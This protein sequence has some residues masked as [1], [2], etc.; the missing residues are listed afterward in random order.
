[1]HGHPELHH[2]SRGAPGTLTRSFINTPPG[3]GVAHK[4]RHAAS[5]E[6]V[7][8]LSECANLTSHT[9]PST[10]SGMRI[11]TP[12]CCR[13]AAPRHRARTSGQPNDALRCH[14][15]ILASDLTHKHVP[16]GTLPDRH[17]N[18][19]AGRPLAINGKSR[20]CYIFATVHLLR[21]AGR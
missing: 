19:M 18:G 11:I 20:A 9:V 5:H 8:F 4:M 2:W 14:T 17:R 16:I 1:V 10:S 7:T 3:I 6:S 12:S 13:R 21:H 15:S